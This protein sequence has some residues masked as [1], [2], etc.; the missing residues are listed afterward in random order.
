VLQVTI[1][2]DPGKKIEH[3][4]I[5]IEFIGL[6]GAPPSIPQSHRADVE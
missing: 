2:L 6:I 1:K 4:G 3:F 5:K